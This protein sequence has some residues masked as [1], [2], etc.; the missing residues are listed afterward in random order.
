MRAIVLLN[1]IVAFSTSVFA[2]DFAGVWKAKRRFGPDARGTLIVE[3]T[4]NAW[5]ADFAGHVVPVRFDNGRVAFALP[6]GAGDFQAE[7]D[8]DRI[9]GHWITPKSVTNGL[10]YAMPVTLTKRSD[11]GWRGAVTPRDDN[12]TLY[13]VVQKR[14]DGTLGAFLRNPE[15]N[16]GVNLNADRIV[17]DG[18]KVRLVGKWNGRGE[19]RDLATGTWN[20]EDGVMSMWIRGATYDFE[21]DNPA[22]SDINARPASG[23]QYAY[24]RPLARDDGWPVATLAAEGLDTKA[25][26]Q[27]VQKI[28]DTPVDSVHAMGVDGFLIARHGKLVLEEYFHGE[29]RDKLHDTRSAGKVFTATVAG[30]AIHDGA[31]TIDT[32]L[33]PN[34]TDARKRNITLEHL[35]T[36]R[37]GFFCDDSNPDAP[38]NEETIAEQQSDPDYI[39]YSLGVPM[40]SEPGG[41]PIYCSMMPN[42]AL[43]MAGKAEKRSA[44]EIFDRRIA[45]PLR[46]TNYAWPLDPAGNPYGGGGIQIT[47]RDFA[48]LGQLMLNGGTWG[49]VRI[50]DRDFVQRASSP[51]YDFN[52]IQYGYLWWNIEFPYK[53]RKVRAYFASGNGGQT[54]M[55]IPDLDLVIG[56]FASNYADRPAVHV[57]QELVPDF[58]LPAVDADGPVVFR[59]FQTPYG[60]H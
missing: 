49:G 56:I 34:D 6:D 7:L 21:R 26:E 35:M 30:A 8:G 47:L 41:K 5:T 38:G 10:R 20:A 32:H 11:G 19:E 55:V 36:M 29:H 57:Q 24:R 3:R 43:S 25:I 39:H 44:V 52:G 1:L 50:L 53:D 42:L 28:I 17:I 27:F 59:D 13:L 9:I 54:A 23:H 37:A 14:A 31:L 16:F 4:A 2:Q 12:F 22:E 45:R 60:H 58:V 18:D 51:S 48:K 40:A 46:I 15:R 33:L